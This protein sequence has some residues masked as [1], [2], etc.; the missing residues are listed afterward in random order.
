[1]FAALVWMSQPAGGKTGEGLLKV[2]K[3]VK[4]W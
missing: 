1:M 2:E 4:R 3:V